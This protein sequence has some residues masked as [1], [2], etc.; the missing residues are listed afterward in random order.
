MNLKQSVSHRHLLLSIAINLSALL[1]LA[2]PSLIR[3]Q[4][5]TT[6]SVVPAA[7]PIAIGE[8]TTVDIVI[9][10][11]NGRAYGSGSYILSFDN[12]VLTANNFQLNPDRLLG[13]V[14]LEPDGT[15]TRIRF[16]AVANLTPFDQPITGS[17]RLATATFIGAAGG[18]SPLTLTFQ[19][20]DEPKDS[21]AESLNA[22]IASS[23]LEVGVVEPTNTPTTPPT[24]TNTATPTTP[25]T[26]TNT[27]TT[28]PTATNTATPTSTPT[29]T[30]TATNTATPTNTPTTPPT[31]TNT[32]T[33]TIPPT[34]TNTPTTPPTA[35]NTATPT[36]TPTT[37]PTATNTA[38]PTIP[39]LLRRRLPTRHAN[40]TADGYQYGHANN[41]PTTPP[42][43]LQIHRPH[44]RRLP[45]PTSTP[46]NTRRPI[47]RLLRRRPPIRQHQPIPRLLRRRLPTRPR[48]PTPR[49]HR[50]RLPIRQHQPAPR[51]QH[52]AL[53]RR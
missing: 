1:F 21:N 31:A 5:G 36:N 23:R 50:L 7:S 51:P 14:N 48:Q 37:P 39:R 27:P 2:I 42:T 40:H 9:N 24:T 17:Q 15:T 33:P 46:T 29:N 45:I 12:T 26:A 35:T 44:R 41:T 19:P 22:Q 25:P 3:A 20:G 52:L 28:P 49:P 47:P 13:A 53:R 18:T 32:A 43:C 11:E 34:A 38:T 8:T 6:V 10:I 4:S 30:P 16:N